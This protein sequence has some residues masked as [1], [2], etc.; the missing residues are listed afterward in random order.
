MRVKKNTLVLIFVIILATIVGYRGSTPDTVV[1]LDIFN[2]INSYNL[3]SYTGFYSDAQVELGWGWYSKIISFF[4]DSSFILFGVFSFLTFWMIYKAN[5]ILRFP[6]IYTLAF[7]LP[8]SFFLMQQFM[9]IRQGL[10]IP[11]AILASF[12]YIDNKK[13]ESFVFF[14]VAIMFHQTAIAYLLVFLLYLFINR[15][16][17]ISFSLKRFL[18]VILSVLVLGFFVARVVVLPLAF[19]A[20]ERLVSYADTEYAE[21]NDLLSLSNIKFYLEF[22]IIIIFSNKK[23]LEDKFYIFM[24]FIFTVGLTIRIAFYDFGILGG[25]LSVVFLFIEIFLIPYLLYRKIKKPYFYFCLIVYFV[26][27][28]Y[29]SWVYQVSQYLQDSYFIPLR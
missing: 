12:L 6:F 10:A 9:Q 11:A 20:F 28:F 27:I 25:R 21:A 26:L 22:I 17:S 24:V 1:Y 18:F 14:I 2:H 4:T 5:N 23:F 15:F 8:S 7:Y 19:S 29:I 3:Y 13:K 16:Y